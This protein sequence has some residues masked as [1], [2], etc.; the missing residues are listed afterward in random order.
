LLVESVP[1]EFTR[2]CVVLPGNDPAEALA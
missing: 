2:F 1:G